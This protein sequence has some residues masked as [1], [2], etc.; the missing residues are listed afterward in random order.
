MSW[1]TLTED[2]LEDY[3]AAPELA[4]LKAFLSS[5]QTNPI[6]GLITAVVG[7][8]R[9]RVAANRNNTLGTGETVPATLLDPAYVIIRH[10]LLGRL[11]QRNLLTPSRQKDYDDAVRLLA[12][13]AAG[14]MAV[15]DPETPTTE[16]TPGPGIEVASSTTRQATRAKLSGL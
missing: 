4:A 11:P 3:L 13:V 1:Q 7:L 5:G 16:T 10:R 9:G 12:D 14:D 6:P 15:E 2:G 8:V